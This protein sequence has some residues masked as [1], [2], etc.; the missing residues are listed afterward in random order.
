MTEHLYHGSK[1]DVLSIDLYFQST[2]TKTTDDW[3]EHTGGL[4]LSIPASSLR[5][6]A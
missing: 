2:R 3:P 4:A 5:M 1:R 6:G